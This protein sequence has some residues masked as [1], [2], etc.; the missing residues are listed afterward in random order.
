MHE[1]FQMPA[2]A[3]F[4]YMAYWVVCGAY[5]IF[6]LSAVFMS[7]AYRDRIHRGT[8]LHVMEGWALVAALWV[9]GVWAH[10]I[11]VT[12]DRDWSAATPL[13]S[14]LRVAAVAYWILAP[15]A[16]AALAVMVIT[17]IVRVSPPPRSVRT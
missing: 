6:V 2:I 3:S 16:L 9:A 5:V 4:V 1:Y 8:W 11:A 15:A 13:P 7:R 14:M 17:T 10:H 12:A